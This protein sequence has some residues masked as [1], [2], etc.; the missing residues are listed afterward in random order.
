MGQIGTFGEIVFEVSSNKI[1]TFNDF[2]RSGSG[3]WSTHEINLQKPLPEFHGPGQEEISF[4]IRLDIQ[5]GV[6][7]EIELEKLRKM[8]DIGAIAYLIVGGRPVSQNMWLL[9]SFREQHKTHDGQGRLLAAIV[10]LSLK[11]YPTQGG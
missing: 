8:R 10:D 2:A 7:P 6:N 11:E 5:L 4:S 3:R 9:E 1:L